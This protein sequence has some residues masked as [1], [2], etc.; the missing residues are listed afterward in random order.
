MQYACDILSWAE[1]PA[2]STAP[3]SHFEPIRESTSEAVKW[4]MSPVRRKHYKRKRPKHVLPP[5]TL[6]PI[7]KLFTV[8]TL[9]VHYFT[10]TYR[11]T[12]TIIFMD[13]LISARLLWL[14][15][16]FLS[17]YLKYLQESLNKNQHIL[18]G[19]PRLLLLEPLLC[20]KKQVISLET[21]LPCTVPVEVQFYSI[22]ELLSHRPT[23]SSVEA[24]LLPQT[25]PR[26]LL[27]KHR[28]GRRRQVRKSSDRTKLYYKTRRRTASFPTKVSHGLSA[29]TTPQGNRRDS[30]IH[31][32]HRINNEA[33]QPAP[34]PR[35]APG[36]AH[37]AN[38]ECQ[39]QPLKHCSPLGRGARVLRRRLYRQWRS[40]CGEHIRNLRLGKVGSIKGKP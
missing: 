29:Q 28:K 32:I 27:P 40:S 35:G 30:V 12:P 33:K 36:A 10:A 26:L 5:T 25:R 8:A 1:T 15:A 21:C 38:E 24:S 9:T 16:E 18:N 4:D 13:S 39:P 3:F 7:F 22:T 31:R 2:F 6:L 23:N 20:E 11:I 37:A 17:S 14:A 19:N 34:P